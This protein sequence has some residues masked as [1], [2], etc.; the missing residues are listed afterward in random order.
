M[1]HFEVEIPHALSPDEVRQRLSGATGR[2]EEKYK[3]ACAWVDDRLLTV[4]R[5]GVDA[6]VKIED[7]RVLV[8][9][10][11]GLLLTPMAGPI[12]A[13]LVRELTSLLAAAPAAP[14]AT[15]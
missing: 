6:K 2:L 14:P 15:T 12:K 9:M 3:V 13:G 8:D 7:A 4:K 5:T 10:S 1:P 11:L